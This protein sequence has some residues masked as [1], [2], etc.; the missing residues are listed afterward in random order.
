[1]PKYKLVCFDVD[2]TLIDNI[3]FSWQLFH[4]YFRT[5]KKVREDVRQRYMDGQISYLDWANHDIGMWLKKK[6]KKEDFFKALKANDVK[7]MQGALETIKELKKHGMKLA[8]ISGSLNIILEYAFPDYGKYFEDVFLS[9]IYFDAKGDV[10]GVKVTEF[11]MMK[12][13]DALKLIAKREKLKLEECVFIGDHHN[14]V[15]IAKEAGL[16]IAFDCKDD[17]LRNIADVVIDKKD[18]RETLRYILE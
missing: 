13:A 18:L 6:A 15:M 9:W 3:I 7:L 11:D 4:D 2:G 16:S 17:G 8:I 12:K 1:M 14:D 5:D 10:T